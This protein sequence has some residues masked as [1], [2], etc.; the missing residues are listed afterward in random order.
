MYLNQVK[1]FSTRVSFHH[2]PQVNCVTVCQSIE[3]SFGVKVFHLGA[4]DAYKTLIRFPLLSTQ[5]TGLMAYH[6]V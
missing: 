4:F 3:Q 5:S 6:A 1:D 2:Q